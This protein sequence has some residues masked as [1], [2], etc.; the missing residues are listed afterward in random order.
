MF[1][2][3]VADELERVR[4]HRKGFAVQDFKGT[5]AIMKELSANVSRT[6]QDTLTE[7]SKRYP[8]ARPEHV[9]RS[10]E[11]TLRLWLKLDI[12]SADIRLGAD[13]PDRCPVDWSLS[14]T[15]DQ[16]L[17][18]QFE[19]SM[20]TQPHGKSLRFDQRFTAAYLVK[21]C[22]IQF[23]WSD[24]IAT[25]LDFELDDL[26]LTVY[27]HKASLISHLSGPQ[28]SPIPMKLLEEVLSTMNLLFPFGNHATKS[29][30]FKE[31][32]PSLW[33]LGTHKPYVDLDLARYGHYGGKLEKLME[34]FDKSARTW[35]QLA[36]DR[37]NKME[38]SA[39]WVTVMVA[40][41]TIISIPSNIIQATYSVKAYQA[42]VSQGKA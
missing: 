16:L 12:H 25:H 27:R 5:F 40:L 19:D 2:E 32:Q 18:E 15:L 34:T 28:G 6:Y 42:T 7:L 26:V 11:L 37:R 9:R 3:Y 8:N 39:F 29:L 14:I 36:L 30:L 20:V 22:G 31:G 21:T 33:T 13:S 38:W 24:D 23:Q 41:L 1:M 4:R 35:K 17:K 10:I